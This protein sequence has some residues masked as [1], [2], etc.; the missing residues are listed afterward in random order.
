MYR[1][2]FKGF[3]RDNKAYT[4]VELI[5]VM[6]IMTTMIGLLS[7]GISVL[8]SRDGERVAKIIDDRISETRMAAMSKPGTFSLRI[9]TT[10]AGSGNYI[11]VEESKLVLKAPV[12]EGP[13]PTPTPTPTSTPG[14]DKTRIDFDRDAYITFGVQGAVP[15]SASDADIKISFD[16]ANGSISEISL[17]GT[18]QSLDNIFEIKC[19]GVRNKTKSASI[20]L[21][22]V[23]GRHY[24]E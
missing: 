17:N 4:L 15:E 22:P 1:S 16:K 11:E 3:S 10:A 14:P 7:L 6:A 18:E 8:F 21:M 12:E 24:I 19:S 9:H 13:A 23:T 5:V 2:A 20:L